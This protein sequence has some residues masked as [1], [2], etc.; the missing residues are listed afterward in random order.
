M[1]YLSNPSFCISDIM[2]EYG[3]TVAAP[4]Y[5]FRSLVRRLVVGDHRSP[6]YTMIYRKGSVPIVIT[7]YSQKDEV[8]GMNGFRQDS[9]PK[10]AL[11]QRPVCHAECIRVSLISA[12]A[13]TLLLPSLILPTLLNLSLFPTYQRHRPCC[14]RHGTRHSN[15]LTLT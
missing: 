7:E 4:T 15:S 9:S 13:I 6:R 8:K 14:L 12:L 10:S 11:Q 5:D 3:A 1:E 2:L